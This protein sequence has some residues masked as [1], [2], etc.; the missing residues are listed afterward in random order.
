MRLGDRVSV[1]GF[2]AA[3]AGA[4]LD[5]PDAVLARLRA[6]RTTVDKAAQ[7]ETPVYGLNT[8]LGGNVAHRLTPDEIEPFQRQ[9]IEGRAVAVG[10]PLPEQIGRAVI[11]ARLVSASRGGS[12]MSPEMA[13]H[14]CAVFRAGLSPAIARFG[15]IGASDL[16]QNA[17]WALAILGQGEMW[18]N[19]T[20]GPARDLLAQNGLN[21]PRLQPKD[22]MALINHG[23]LS[24]VLSAH[25]LFEAQQGLLMARAAAALSYVGYQANT[26]I[27]APDINAIRASPSQSQVAAWFARHLSTTAP[28]RRIQDAI[29]FRVVA[30][31]FGAAFDIVSR[32][33]AIWEDEANGL[34]DSPVVLGAEAMRSTPNFHAPA[35]ALALESGAQAMAMVANAMVQRSQRM[36]SPELSGL[37]KYLSPVG[38]ASA[39]MVPLQKTAAALLGDIRRHAM[40]VAF[41]PAPVS[42]TVEDMAPMTAHAA[43]K[44]AEQGQSFQL[45][46]G[47]EAIVAAQAVDLRGAPPAVGAIATLH[48]ALRA[49]VAPLVQDRALGPD[50]S[51]CADVLRGLCNDSKSPFG[52]I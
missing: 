24:V 37:P 21:V 12:G 26:D 35:L 11:L 46:C 9:L 42:E 18:S 40:P 38:G 45:L 48:S 1:S 25:A 39:G 41:D 33:S 29:S 31:V 8:G 3:L 43:Q 44:L 5:L 23:G 22:A 14:L 52:Q 30:P 4:D 36:M 2:Q 20:I 13:A 49:R 47:L 34:S 51:I 7:G 32:A 27:F 10:P 28:A 6:D 50:V 17:G 16:T 19:G 15:S